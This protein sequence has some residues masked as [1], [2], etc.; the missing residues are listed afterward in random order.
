MT[1]SPPEHAWEFLHLG[2]TARRPNHHLVAPLNDAVLWRRVGCY[3]LPLH[4]QLGEVV[5]EVA[6]HELAP[7]I[8]TQGAKLLP[9]LLFRRR[10]DILAGRRRAVFGGQQHNPH[11]SA[12]IIHQQKKIAIAA[13]SLRCDRP[14]DI[15]VH[16]FQRLYC[17]PERLLWKWCSAML[18]SK[19]RLTNLLDLR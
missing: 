7:T 11:I 12:K 17:L 6:R 4:T 8:G 16:E 5:V 2:H 10:L 19:A 14:I 15:S 9:T 18:A 3:E 13:W 1:A